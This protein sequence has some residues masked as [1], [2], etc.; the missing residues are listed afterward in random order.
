MRHLNAGI[1]N[2]FANPI[3]TNSQESI[4][5][6]DLIS[7]YTDLV[8]QRVQDG[9]QPYL[10]T[11]MFKRLPGNKSSVIKQ[12]RDE[13]E[14]VYATLVTRVVRKPRSPKSADRLPVL[15][16]FADL[17][18]PKREKK[19][20]REIALNDGLHYHGILLLPGSSRLRTGLAFHFMKYRRLYV[21]HGSRLDRLHLHQIESDP[22]YVVRYAFKALEER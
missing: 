22:G 18:V 1:W 14:R 21:G 17:P 15:I 8:E 12:M 7:G 6:T 16:G 5:H 4:S 20:L 13:I 3:T 2:S 11:F 9:W 10:I 19:Q